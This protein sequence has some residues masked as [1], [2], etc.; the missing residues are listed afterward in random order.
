MSVTYCDTKCEECC[1]VEPSIE[2]PVDTYFCKISMTRQPRKIN[3]MEVACGC[4]KS[5]EWDT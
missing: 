1:Y 5:K 4:F 2:C 3:N